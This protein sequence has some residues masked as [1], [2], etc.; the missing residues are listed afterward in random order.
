MKHK[1]T[2]L[3]I[4]SCVFANAQTVSSSVISTAGKTSSS[5]DVALDWTLGQAVA[6]QMSS[7]DIQLSN[8]YHSQLDLQFLSITDET[9]TASLAIYPNPTMDYVVLDLKPNDEVVV[10]VYNEV[11]QNLLTTE[12]NTVQNKIN[13]DQLS[14][15]IY[16]FTVNSKISNKTNSYKIIKK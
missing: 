9:I 4:A 12:L 5:S 10:T 1:I 14:S 7:T 2:M 8:G 16:I 13:L 6:G 3:A 11:G 15:G